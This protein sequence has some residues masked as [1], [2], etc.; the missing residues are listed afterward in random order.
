M[1]H[2]LPWRCR[3][4]PA[5]H[6]YSIGR[7]RR[8]TRSQTQPLDLRFGSGLGR[9]RQP[10]R[11]ESPKAFRIDS[12]R[13]LGFGPVQRTH[14]PRRKR[15]PWPARTDGVF[16]SAWM[17][18]RET[19]VPQKTSL[20]ASAVVPS[21]LHDRAQPGEEPRHEARHPGVAGDDQ[22]PVGIRSTMAR[23]PGTPEGPG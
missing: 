19:S 16:S 20:L 21:T 3:Q 18:P 14:R 17:L 15:A 23:W 11:W 5:S 22:E 8:Q 10:R 2:V 12:N 9:A 6:G 13:S 4:A 1:H 7:L